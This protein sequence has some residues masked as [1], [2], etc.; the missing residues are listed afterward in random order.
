MPD[1]SPAEAFSASGFAR[2]A[3]LIALL[4]MP[5]F[6]RAQDNGSPPRAANTAAKLE[7][8]PHAPL[9][10]GSFKCGAVERAG[11]LSM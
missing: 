8:L 4:A 2:I 3:L 10:Q 1:R 11:F 9:P 7:A 6:S 5:S